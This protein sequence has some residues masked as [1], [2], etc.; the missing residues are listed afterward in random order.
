MN[1]RNVCSQER[2]KGRVDA[3]RQRQQTLFEERA[4]TAALNRRLTTSR[5]RDGEAKLAP[6]D[7]RDAQGQRV[8]S[9]SSSF[10]T[11]YEIATSEFATRTSLEN[12]RDR[13]MELVANDIRNQLALNFRQRKNAAR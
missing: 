8:F 9:G 5:T 6:F 2:D 4:H 12:A 1:E 3:T 10:T 11:D 7:L 13:V